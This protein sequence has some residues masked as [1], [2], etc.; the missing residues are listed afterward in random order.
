[1]VYKCNLNDVEWT[2]M[3]NGEQIHHARKTL[4]PMDQAYRPKLGISLFRLQPGKRSFPLHQHMANDE[5]ILVTKGSGTLQYGDEEILLTEGDY[6][7]LPAASGVAHHMHNSSDQDLEYYCL[8]SI[9]V[10]EVVLYPDSNKLGAFSLKPSADGE[11]W[12][13]MGFILRNE[14]VDYFDGEKPGQK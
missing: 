6:A 8:S 2:E 13:R 10:P 3:G 14:P 1:M 12:Q 9:I 4:T 11:G 7:H 5:A